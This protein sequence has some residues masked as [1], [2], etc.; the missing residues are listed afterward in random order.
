MKLSL[1]VTSPGPNEGKE[2]P[3]KLSQFLIGRDQQCHLRPASALISKRHC[4]LIQKGE[5]VYLRDFGSTN[6][7]FINDE[8]VSGEQEV[9][10]EDSLKVGP[11]SFKVKLEKTAAINK[12]TPPP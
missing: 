9:H 11:L 5:Q 4:A 6:G 8:P 1:V 10:H 12:P 7:T 3:V 2:I